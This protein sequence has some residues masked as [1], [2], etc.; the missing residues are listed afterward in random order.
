M[1]NILLIQT[2]GTIGSITTDGIADIADNSIFEEMIRTEARQDI[3]ID[4]E[5]PLR[6]LSENLVPSVWGAIAEAVRK[7]QSGCYDGILIT[8]GSDTLPYT[9][10]ML[11]YLFGTHTKI[12]I[13]I[14]ASNFPPADSRSNARDNLTAAVE[15]IKKSIPGCY[16]IWTNPGCKTD[17]HLATRLSEAGYIRDTFHF[18]GDM[19]HGGPL[20]PPDIP[21]GFSFDL[22]FIYMIKNYPGLNYASLDFTENARPAAILHVLYHSATG[23]V[24]EDLRYDLP[25]FVRRM[26]QL[27]IPVY[28]LGFKEGATTYAGVPSV[29]ESG[30]IPVPLMTVEAALVKLQLAYALQTENP[31]PLLQRNWYYELLG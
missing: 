24:T 7:G 26:A 27:G 4:S 6:L 11:G 28:G 15:F 29:L 30:L 2:G 19:P 21:N 8:H 16:V 1:C 25:S 5:R 13:V 12:P 20:S 17:L 22:P 18:N 14:T 10:A 31:L 9:A 23:C 3:L